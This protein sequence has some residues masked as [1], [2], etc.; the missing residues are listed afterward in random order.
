LKTF[1]PVKAGAHL[2]LAPANAT[3]SENWAALMALAQAGDKRAYADLL[4]NITPYIRALARRALREH[5]DIDEVVQDVLL[6]IHQIRHTYDPRRPFAPWLTTIA[7]RRIID[8]LRLNA[9]EAARKMAIAATVLVDAGAEPS[10]HEFDDYALRQAVDEL[11]QGQ[12]KA[13]ELLKLRELSLIEASQHSG[14]SVGS[15]K[16]ATHRAY[17]TLRRLLLERGALS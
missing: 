17:K 5:A 1:G 11:P 9:G 16:T 14:M 7:R 4:T 2:R 13:I 10:R 15:L 12:R 3:P 6:T 8:R